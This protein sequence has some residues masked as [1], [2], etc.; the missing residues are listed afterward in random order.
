M[1]DEELKGEK[2]SIDF[3]LERCQKL[4]NEEEYLV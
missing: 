4:I 1:N 2:K 3:F